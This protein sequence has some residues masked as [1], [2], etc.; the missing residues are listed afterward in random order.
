MND[1]LSSLGLEHRLISNNS[2]IATDT[3]NFSDVNKR[4]EKLRTL[5]DNFLTTALS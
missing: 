1:F 5:S 4:L 3:I 2:Q